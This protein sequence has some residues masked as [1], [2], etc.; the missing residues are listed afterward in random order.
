M[1]KYYNLK[2]DYVI[3]SMGIKFLASVALV[4]VLMVL[5]VNAIS[6]SPG[7]TNVPPNTT[8]TVTITADNPTNPANANAIRLHLGISGGTINSFTIGSGF[9]ITAGC[10]G[11][12]S[13]YSSSEICAD[14]AKAGNI[15]GA[16][17]GTFR[18]T[19][20]A[21]GTIV[22]TKLADNEYIDG[23]NNSVIDSGV[24][25]TYPIVAGAN[26]LP[27]TALSDDLGSFGQIALGLSFF[28]VALIMLNHN[29]RTSK[30]NIKNLYEKNI[31]NP[32]SV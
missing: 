11:L 25:A 3:F 15:A 19:S 12:S 2:I 9:A 26:I 5:P 10:N 13:M 14:I 6:L 4:S 20:G 18:L 1:C 23:N 32:V 30:T 27:K 28:A 21:L 22:I 8:Y 29:Y 16:T 7:T 31:L 24:I 17:L